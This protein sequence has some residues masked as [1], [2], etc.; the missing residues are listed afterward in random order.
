MCNKGLMAMLVCVGL[1]CLWGMRAA[2]QTNAERPPAT[3]GTAAEEGWQKEFDAICSKTTDAMSYSQ[4]ELGAM[5]QRCDTLMPQVE[6]L[7]ETRKKVY[8]RRLRA[9][10]GLY[11]YVLESK[12]NEKK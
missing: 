2:G 12:K 1:A 10:R 9:C 6:K 3:K 4:E 5:I 8:T 11:G 7:D